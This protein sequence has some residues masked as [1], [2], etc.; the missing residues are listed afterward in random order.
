VLASDDDGGGSLNSRI[1]S[2]S[3]F[4]ALPAT[5]TYTIEVTSSRSNVT[6][7]Y[8]VSLT[9]GTV[10]CSYGIV[11]SSQSFNS[12]GGT[13]SIAVTTGGACA[14]TAITDAN[15]VTIS[16]GNS[17]TGNGTVNYTVATNTSSS[18]RTANLFVAGLVFPITQLGDSGFCAVTA[19]T[20]GQVINGAL[21]RMRR[22]M[23]FC[24][25]WGRMGRCWRLTTM[26]EVTQTHEFQ[27]GADSSPCRRVGLIR[28]R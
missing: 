20:S 8:T 5:G 12:T 22:S 25:C 4:L 13:R 10:G 27:A 9:S 18:P 24:I 3:G 2:G 15:W 7:S 17:G 23:R 14:W 21:E 19:I 6:G 11:P 16:G 26:V 1:P 28:L